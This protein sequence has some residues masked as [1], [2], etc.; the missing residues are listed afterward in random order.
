MSV[1][2]LENILRVMQD[3]RDKKMENLF[4]RQGKATTSQFM[5]LHMLDDKNAL[6]DETTKFNPDLVLNP[7]LRQKQ[8]P[9]SNEQELA[10]LK[11]LF[12][13]PTQDAAECGM[14]QKQQI[15]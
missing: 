12:S 4:S 6:S 11:S 14:A 1:V 7:S 5:I 15:E 2:K 10:K 9:K 8:P 3:E 13:E